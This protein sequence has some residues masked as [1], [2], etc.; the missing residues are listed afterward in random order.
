M[1][2]GITNAAV[3]MGAVG[4]R[5]GIYE[6]MMDGADAAIELFHGYTYSGHPLAC[7]AGLATLDTY[8]DEGLF[9][10]AANLAP[11]FEAAVHSLRDAKHVID[12]R[13]IGLV[14]GIELAPRPGE[15]GE[16]AQEVFRAC[17]DRGLLVRVTA[18]IIALSPSLII[19]E[20]QIDEIVG[21]LREVLS[22]IA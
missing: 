22:Q 10:R 15:A 14:A 7:A 19:E 20:S 2:K 12:I 1:A 9:E 13:N 5:R 17:F 8:R 4:V 3:P 21:T 11:T 18:D 16:R 6:A